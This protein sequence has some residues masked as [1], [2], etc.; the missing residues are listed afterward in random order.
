MGVLSVSGEE[1]QPWGGALCSPSEER[2]GRGEE[3]QGARG[4]GDGDRGAQTGAEAALENLSR[5]REAGETLLRSQVG[6]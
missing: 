6:N 4:G 2:L 5:K 3:R 1:G